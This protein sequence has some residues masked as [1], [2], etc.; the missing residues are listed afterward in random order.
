ML[1]LSATFNDRPVLSLRTGA[2]IAKVVTPIINPDNLKI[3]GFFCEDRYSKNM[4]VLLTQDIRDVLPN[5]YVV[6]D[7][8]V[9]SAPEE[10]IRLRKV[11]EKPFNPIG[12]KVVTISKEKVGKVGDYAVDTSSMYIQKIYATRS[13]LKSLTGGSLIIDRTQ[14]NEV[15]PRQIIINDLLNKNRAPA[16]A[17]APNLV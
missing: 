8:D 10:L 1:Q 12:K 2:L 13:I 15:T 9:L 11:L 16:P 6:N 14:I 17:A 3:E 7:H 4:L 5:G